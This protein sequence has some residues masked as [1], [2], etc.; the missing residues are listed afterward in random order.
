M[1]EG[2]ASGGGVGTSVRWTLRLFGRFGLTTVPSGE[3]VTLSGRRERVL[4]AYLALSPNGRASR[5]K[6]TA[7]LWGSDSDQ[8]MLDNLRVCVWRLRKAFGDANHRVIASEGEDIALDLKA[9]EV[10]VL[11]F[12]RLA[13]SSV[14]TELEVAARLYGGEFLE[15]LDI[16]SEEFESWRREQA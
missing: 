3:A 6:L 5:R 12:R 8:T 4:L 1:D 11:T 2:S 15:E 7:L 14:T 16:E 9:I 10:D 13:A